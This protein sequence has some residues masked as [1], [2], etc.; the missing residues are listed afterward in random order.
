MA[1]FE[2]IAFTFI[3]EKDRDERREV[4]KNLTKLEPFEHCKLYG[5]R[6]KHNKLMIDRFDRFNELVVRSILND[7]R[8]GTGLMEYYP[9]NIKKTRLKNGIV[10]FY[11][12][13]KHT[14]VASFSIN[15]LVYVRVWK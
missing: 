1:T 14:Q 10:E 6:I 4:F 2:Y 5:Q 13:Y 7:V 12:K 9:D 3:G 8:V 15:K 11:V